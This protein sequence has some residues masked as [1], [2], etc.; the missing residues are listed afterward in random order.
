MRKRVCLTENSINF[1]SKMI[2][3]I[4]FKRDAP[5]RSCHWLSTF[6]PQNVSVKLW[7]AQLV[8]LRRHGRLSS[9]IRLPRH[10]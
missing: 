8:V 9:V 5:A 2:P 7:E 6:L 4:S 3:N 10:H 1:P